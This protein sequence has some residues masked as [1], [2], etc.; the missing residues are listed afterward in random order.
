MLVQSTLGLNFT[1]I[2]WA[3]FLRQ[4]ILHSFSI[5]TIW[6]WNFLAKENLA[7]KLL[8]NVDEIVY[9][10]QYFLT[11]FTLK[12]ISIANVLIN[13]VVRFLKAFWKSLYIG[14]LKCH[15]T[16]MGGGR[17]VP[18]SPNAAWGWGEGSK[19]VPKSVTY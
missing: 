15:F 9:K 18:V 5:V 17:S 2:L 4:S 12:L 8:V 19:I 7:K 10:Y 16:R 13:E 6:L 14:K 11:Y 3:A 1:N